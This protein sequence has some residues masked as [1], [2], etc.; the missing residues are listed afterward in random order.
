[1]ELGGVMLFLCCCVLLLC[2]LCCCVV[3]VIV[4]CSGVLSRARCSG[5]GVAG[6]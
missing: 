4:E 3:V 6:C 2:G 1:M 5:V